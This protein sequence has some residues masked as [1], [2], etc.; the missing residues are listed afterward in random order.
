MTEPKPASAQADWEAIRIDF[1]AGVLSLREIAKKHDNAVSHVQI[2][3]RADKEGWT[4]DLKAKIDHKAEEL[5][6]R[7]AVREEQRA[8]ARVN[9]GVVVEANA[10]AIADVRLSHRRD[11][12]TARTLSMQLLAR[13]QGET[14]NMPALEELADLMRREDDRGRDRL[15]DIYRAVISTPGQIKAMKDL[16]ATMESLVTMEREAYGI[17]T[18]TDKPKGYEDLSDDELNTKLNAYLGRPGSGSAPA[19]AG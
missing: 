12:A 8:A 17:G 14:D 3:R 7:E 18:G 13:L 1:E 19:A 16:A 10:R 9:E 4:R 6:R 15:N 2:K 11:I 5:V